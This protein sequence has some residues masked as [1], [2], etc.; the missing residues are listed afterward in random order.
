MESEL[1]A[2]LKQTAVLPISDQ[3]SLVCIS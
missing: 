1:Q 2:E 3:I